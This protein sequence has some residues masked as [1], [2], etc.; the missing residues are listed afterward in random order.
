MVAAAGLFLWLRSS[1]V[2][3]VNTVVATATE[4]VT[5]EEIVEATSAAMGVS[6]L[7][8]STGAIE[9]ALSALPYVRSAEVYRSFPNGL[10]VRV[11]EYEPV[12]RVQASQGDRV[13]GQ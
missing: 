6:L 2:F 7:R 12:A 5:R 9:E 10:E 11:V 3:A 4:R 8:L 1:S 13:A